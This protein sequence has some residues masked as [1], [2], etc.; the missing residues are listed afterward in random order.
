MNAFLS[1]SNGQVDFNNL[2]FTGEVSGSPPTLSLWPQAF[3]FA[4]FVG[5]GVERQ[6]LRIETAGGT[7]N[8]RA[9]ARILN[10]VGWLVVTPPSGT[11]TANLPSTLGLDVNFGAF[12][13]PGTYQ[14]EILIEQTDGSLQARVPVTVVVSPA[15]SR[16]LLSQSS[17]VFRTVEGGAA[18]ARTLRIVNGG[19]GSMHWTIPA[20]ETLTAPL[21]WLGIS[22]LSGSASGG[23]SG[24]ATT[25]SVNT[26]GLAAGVYQARVPVA[27]PAAANHLQLVAVTLHV[28]PASTPATPELSSH[29]IL[30]VIREGAIEIPEFDFSVRNAGGGSATFQ[31]TATT[32][33]ER[34]WLT[35]SSASGSIGALASNLSIRPNLVGL[36]LGVFRGHVTISFTPGGTREVE[37]V[38]IHSDVPIVTAREIPSAAQCAASSME[39][40]VSS[41]GTGSV[42]PVSF[43]RPLLAT[44]VDSCGTPL[45]DATVAATIE[46]H[47]IVL[48]SLGDGFYSGTWVP[49]QEAA[50]VAV[51]FLV[52][53]PTYPTVERTITVSTAAAAGGISLPVLFAE[54]VVEGAAFT[55]RR[56]LAPGGIVSLFGTSF[57]VADASATQLPLDRNLGGVSVRI[58]G[59]DAPLYF[60]GAGQ[61][62][63]QVPY[64]VQTGDTVS[65]VVSV[66][67]LLTAP[68]TYQ[69]APAQPGIFL[70][71]GGGGAILDAQSRLVSAENPAQRG[72][73]LQIFTTG[74]G[75]TDPPGQTGEGAP[76]FSRVLLPVTVTV[77]GVEA[78]VDYEGLAPGFVGLY[79]VNAVLP[80]TVTPGNNVEVVILQNGIASNPDRPATIP[81]Q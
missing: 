55:A 79:Q 48:A 26:A 23:G 7:L 75:E 32:E 4:G 80:T 9:T 77:G 64:S 76:S 35:V 25:L 81:V 54:G 38:L 58:G 30:F 18:R 2:G 12:S 40:V 24:S 22:S 19:Q 6:R 53:H 70:D 3:R 59:E 50:S 27:A 78:S 1:G 46:G 14:A 10:G 65:V 63:A 33:S 72:T 45:S 49:E 31:L 62:N 44:V 43:P 41:I 37:V 47:L 68:Q 61:I 11:A 16:L 8:W 39:M 20:P 21:S 28:A 71:E 56:P 57:A 67:G 60:A 52:L 29:G 66:N 69:I 17:F 34:N 13:V 15:G 51:S 36:P 5:G 73:V 74:L 42:V